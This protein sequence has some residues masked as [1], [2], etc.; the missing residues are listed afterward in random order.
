MRKTI[1]I[2]LAAATAAGVLAAP[3]AADTPLVSDPTVRNVTAYGTTAAWSRRAEDGTHRLVVRSGG[4][5]TDA[6]VAPSSAAYDPDLGPGKDNS[7]VIVYARGGDLYEYVVGVGGERPIAALSGRYRAGAPSFFKGVIA[8]ARVNGPR[9]GLY[10]Y[11]PG[12]GAAKRLSRRTPA[13]T[14]VAATR[15]AWSYVDVGVASIYQTNYTGDDTRRVAHTTSSDTVLTSPIL[16]RF[17]V[18]WVQRR[19]GAGQATIYRVGVNAHR[20]LSPQRSTRTLPG[21]VSSIGGD[22]EPTVHANG[23]GIVRIEPHL[24]FAG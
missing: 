7:R 23:S 9:P 22:K 12:T 11:R 16:S 2:L 14:D 5:V 4:V 15:V 13:Q 6:P 21:V 20:G 8:F 10:L 3:A 18:F 17:N 19:A 24:R 1:P